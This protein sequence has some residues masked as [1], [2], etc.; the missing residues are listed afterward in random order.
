MKLL[1]SVFGYT[2]SFFFWVIIVGSYS[3]ALVII[4]WF[5]YVSEI[6]SLMYECDV[7][8]YNSLCQCN[9][10]TTLKFSH[11]SHTFY[12]SVN[13]L[14]LLAVARRNGVV[15]HQLVKLQSREYLKFS[16]WLPL[17]CWILTWNWVWCRLSWSTLLMEIFVHPFLML[18]INWKMMVLLAC[19]YSEDRN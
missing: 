6:G 11:S 10:S 2:P 12:S 16:Y 13:L 14:Q 5:S 4:R 7:Y 1:I 15:S 3:C 18:T 19:I 8:K 17:I 9:R